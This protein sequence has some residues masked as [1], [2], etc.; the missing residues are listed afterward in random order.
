VESRLIR[1]LIRGDRSAR[2][3]TPATR[4]IEIAFT[5]E[6]DTIDR[7][8]DVSREG[9]AAWP[10]VL[11]TGAMT[12]TLEEA[13]LTFRAG[14]TPDA[15]VEAA[16][17]EAERELGREHALDSLRALVR[18][19]DELG[20]GFGG[21]RGGGLG[22]RH[23]ERARVHAL[24]RL[25]ERVD[26]LLP[27]VR[28]AIRF[29]D[30]VRPAL[31]LEVERAIALSRAFV[32]LGWFAHGAATLSSADLALGYLGPHPKQ[33]FEWLRQRASWAFAAREL[34]EART[35]VRE[36]H[37]LFR[38]SPLPEGEI[39]ALVDELQGWLE[40]APVRVLVADVAARVKGD[41][42]LEG[43]L[44]AWDL[45]S[46]LFFPWD[47]ALEG[48]LEAR[49]REPTLPMLEALVDR[50]G[51]SLAARAAMSPD[52]V[53]R[54]AL[55][56]DG[57]RVLEL[58]DRLAELA[59]RGGG[60]E[61]ALRARVVAHEQMLDVLAAMRP[62]A[63]E[64]MHPIDGA[65]ARELLTR[66]SWSTEARRERLDRL[67]ADA[68][69]TATPRAL[70]AMVAD[71]ALDP[72]IAITLA[73]P[74]LEG[75]PDEERLDIAAALVDRSALR[76]VDERGSE[77]DAA[78]LAR[79]WLEGA[80]AT[81]DRA[82]S[83]EAKEILAGALELSGDLEGALQLFEE[84]ATY[85]EARDHDRWVRA[86]ERCAM[87]AKQTGRL[88]SAG[89]AARSGFRPGGRVQLPG[90]DLTV[91]TDPMQAEEQAERAI[92]VA[93]RTTDPE[94][95]EAWLRRALVLYERV[96]D[97]RRREDE[98]WE[99]IAD[100]WQSEADALFEAGDATSEQL[101]EAHRRAHEALVRA[102]EVDE[103]LGDGERVFELSGRVLDVLWTWLTRWEDALDAFLALARGRF[104]S[105]VS[106]G[107]LD[108]AA[109]A[110]LELRAHLADFRADASE[111]DLEHDDAKELVTRFEEVEREMGEAVE[112]ETARLKE[113]WWVERLG[114]RE[115][116][117][118]RRFREE[119]DEDGGGDD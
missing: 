3:I 66:G 75:E 70:A 39:D 91:P 45:A 34:E 110:R 49:L 88:A 59:A 74:A 112:A 105:A 18:A 92:A 68:G 113:P 25:R 79:R 118:E 57:G 99:R 16:I 97:G 69:Q 36:Y 96:P 73:A 77:A 102:I 81:T 33:R 14:G 85:F 24:L 42:V 109:A 106:R 56:E 78:A 76:P 48:E 115:A 21:V 8:I 47:E 86:I 13:L 31:E 87:L 119:D 32:E 7:R 98:I 58:L 38:S 72:A 29:P 11:T 53:P 4:T 64:A 10:G 2:S 23:V 94:V 101:D 116:L 62:E 82:L 20:A 61:L 50:V 12:G 46:T 44:L 111:L 107:D 89:R 27:R 30:D 95:G 103:D 5:A 84:L 6:G 90:G 60:R 28:R 93:L 108:H 17:E 26:A 117:I 80:V 52:Q 83:M 114:R 104:R 43:N 9:R 63:I 67:R 22:V 55:I 71:P 100:L 41:A 19:E 54:P 51:E 40:V 37:A 35:A 65:R 15:V 1:Y